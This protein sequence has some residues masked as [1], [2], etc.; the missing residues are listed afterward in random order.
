MKE[1]L[2]KYGFAIE[3]LAPPTLALPTSYIL[4]IGFGDGTHLAGMAMASPDVGYIGCEPYLNGVA[5]L[6][7]MIKKQAIENIM[8]YQDDALDLLNLLPHDFLKQIYILFP[9]PWSKTKHHKR[10][11]INSQNLALFALKLQSQ[12]EIIIATD[13]VEYAE[14]IFEHLEHSNLFNLKTTLAAYQC[15]PSNWI[16]T[17]YQKKAED[18]GIKPYFF[19]VKKLT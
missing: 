7:G 1:M 6:L 2:P 13:H 3:K 4:E 16:K 10:R 12:G 5:S 19:I 8:I 9:D 11:I 18:Q 17:K 14:W 15:E